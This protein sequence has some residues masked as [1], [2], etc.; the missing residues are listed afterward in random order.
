MMKVTKAR[1][2]HCEYPKMVPLIPNCVN[3]IL[4]ICACRLHLV[5]TK[6]S[7]LFLFHALGKV[8]FNK[9]ELEDPCKLC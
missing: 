7:S 9:S 5:E 3:A 2:K 8:L 4:T 6:E 1:T